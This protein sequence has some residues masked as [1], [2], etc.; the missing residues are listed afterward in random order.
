MKYFFVKFFFLFFFSS[1]SVA[2][3]I[4]QL[5]K[6]EDILKL[7]FPKKSIRSL[8]SQ[9][10]LIHLNILFTANCKGHHFF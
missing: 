1:W 8:I 7:I 10:I 4:I 9:G 5:T 6:R 2:T 3:A